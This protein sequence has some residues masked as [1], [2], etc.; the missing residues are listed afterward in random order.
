MRSAVPG[1]PMRRSADHVE[2]RLTTSA[3]GFSI[4]ALSVRRASAE[5]HTGMTS[6][7][8][9]SR[10]AWQVW[11]LRIRSS[12]KRSAVFPASSRFSLE[13]PERMSQC[14]RSRRVE[15]D[16]A[17]VAAVALGEWRP[18][19]MNWCENASVGCGGGRAFGFERRGSSS[20]EGL[21]EW[22]GVVGHSR[23]GREHSAGA[24]G[25]PSVPSLRHE[26][27]PLVD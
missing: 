20:A 13:G 3:D 15:P 12:T 23:P 17:P 26:E 14:V 25:C 24:A 21:T 2:R 4:R 18:P 27:I 10:N 11:R 7:T 8:M 1:G 5:G 19:R 6:G 22:T 9:R 16:D